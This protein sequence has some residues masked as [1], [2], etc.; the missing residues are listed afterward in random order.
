MK[1]GNAIVF[2]ACGMLLFAGWRL[3]YR[4]GGNEAQQIAESLSESESRHSSFDNPVF[5][6]SGDSMKAESDE[7][8]LPD[9]GVLE[10][11]H[12]TL[13]ILEGGPNADRAVE[14]LA[15]LRQAISRAQEM[16]AAASILEFLKGG[17]DAPTGLPFR[18]GADGVLDSAP[19]LRVWLLD[20]LPSLD[21]MASVVQARSLLHSTNSADEYAMALRNLAWNDLDG[22]ME[23]VLTE[24]FSKMLRREDWMAFPTAGFLEAFDIS[25]FVGGPEMLRLLGELCGQSVGDRS[26]LDT[27][28]RRAAFMAF[29]RA[30]LRNPQD[31]V[32]VFEANTEFLRNSPR[33]R[34]AVM[35]R[36]DPRD[37][38][39]KE[40]FTNYLEMEGHGDGEMDYF[41]VLFP[42]GNFFH[43]P[44]LATADESTPSIEQRLETDRAI[45]DELKTIAPRLKGEAARKTAA[46]LVFKLEEFTDTGAKLGEADP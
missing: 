16:E 32:D 29:D 21:P 5:D 17:R 38:A 33:L 3:V 26:P 18:V 15:L 20:L 34:A 25:A 43:G 45:L 37:P 30:V 41:L 14:A 13:R 9:S 6:R 2:V 28:V 8:I 39:Q 27:G 22:D 12:G 7:M 1:K 46:G 11:M 24:G 4:T 31:L 10:E 19:S 44:R 36:L 42:N 23:E 35:S 40:L